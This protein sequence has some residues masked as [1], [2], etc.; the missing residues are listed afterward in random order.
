MTDYNGIPKVKNVADN[1]GGRKEFN[2]LVTKV[3]NEAM[4][5]MMCDGEKKAD[6]F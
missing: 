3:I 5:Q 2:Y 6:G 4:S 1:V